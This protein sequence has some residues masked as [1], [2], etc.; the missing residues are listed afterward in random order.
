MTNYFK[1]MINKIKG[2]FAF[3]FKVYH[4][5]AKNFSVKFNCFILIMSLHFGTFLEFILF[6][7]DSEDLNFEE[8]RGLTIQQ[9]QEI[10]IID[11]SLIQDNER[12]SICMESFMEQRSLVLRQLECGHHYHENCIFEWLELHST[13]PLCRYALINNCKLIYFLK[14]INL[15]LTFISVQG[16]RLQNPGSEN[17]NRHGEYGKILKFKLC[18]LSRVE[19]GLLNHM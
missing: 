11:R 17:A 7:L 19:S 15:I 13:C 18:C 5:S 14:N 3:C 16:A 12:C 6:L 9:M 2:I 8:N 1:M 4:F 10:E